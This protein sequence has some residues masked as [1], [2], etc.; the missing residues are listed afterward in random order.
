[1]QKKAFEAHLKMKRIVTTTKNNNDK[2][3]NDEK[4]WNVSRADLY[5][6]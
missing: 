5:K 1:M 4:K 6:K 2:I 3:A